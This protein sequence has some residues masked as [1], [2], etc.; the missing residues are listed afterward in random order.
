MRSVR[1][2]CSLSLHECTVYLLQYPFKNCQDKHLINT[3]VTQF[4]LKKD[5]K[6]N[7]ELLVILLLFAYPDLDSEPTASLPFQK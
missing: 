4:D 1:H 6:A 3:L 7:W 5:G 2:L